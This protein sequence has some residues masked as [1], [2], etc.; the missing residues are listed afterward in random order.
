MSLIGNLFQL[1]QNTV[2]SVNLSTAETTFL[3]G[4][5]LLSWSP[6][7]GGIF[8]LEL[9]LFDAPARSVSLQ[10]GNTIVFTPSTS[11][12]AVDPPYNIQV[13]ASP[14]QPIQLVANA[15]ILAV[16]ADL[17]ITQIG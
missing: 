3:M 1:L 6:P 5:T 17:I 10:V 9:H 11:A 13:V 2:A 8:K 15:N 4:D 14:S 7:V 16:Y 12:L